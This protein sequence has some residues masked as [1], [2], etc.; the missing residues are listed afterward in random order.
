V[1]ATVLSVT[2][3]FFAEVGDVD[4][5][6]ALDP[7]DLVDI[8]E[9]F[10]KYAVLVF[11]GQ[12]LTHE[13]HLAFA[14]TF[15]PL[16]TKLTV[17]R[18]ESRDQAPGQIEDLS[19]LDVDDQIR[20]ED[21]RVR[22]MQLGNRLW[23]TDSSFKRVPA[24]ASLLYAREV[25]PIG[26]HTQFADLRAAYDSLSDELKERLEGL[27]AEH[28]FRYSRARIG[29]EDLSAEENDDLPPVPQ[30]MVRTHPESGRRTLYLAS[31]MGRVLGLPETES[32]ALI[33]ELIAHATQR[34]FVH[35]HR[36]RVNDLVMWDDRCTMH[37]GT[38]F[39]DVRWRRD[40]RRATVSDELNT[41]EREG[42][43]VA[44]E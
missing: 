40:V 42:I 39:D 12:H 36:W 44:A 15:G 9:A 31:H 32:D 7:G 8:K 26:G 27:I 21:D 14:A 10:A 34:Q 24:R 37:R 20:P 18:E 2:P 17:Y 1:S 22:Q 28:A 35:T 6:Q 33:D 5:S 13:Q 16:E 11:P 3:D 25:P 41:Y 23:H 38:A 4:L 43:A 19:N 30:V 29:F